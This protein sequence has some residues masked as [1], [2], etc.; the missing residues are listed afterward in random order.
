M[1]QN[2]P[3]SYQQD[4]QSLPHN[5][6][7]SPGNVE[8]WRQ[9][10][11]QQNQGP[12]G[13]A[14]PYTSRLYQPGEEEVHA[15]AAKLMEL[16]FAIVA[17]AE[18][19]VEELKEKEN[20]RLK[21]EQVC[22]ELVTG[23]EFF[24]NGMQI[25]PHTIELKCF[26][27]LASGF[28]TKA[29][30]MDL[31]LLSPYS[32]L[33]PDAPG[34]PLPR[35][36]EKAFLEMG[37][38]A[39]LLTR[40]RVPIIKI[41]ERPPENLRADLIAARVKWEAGE[42]VGVDGLDEEHPDEP[43]P[44]AAD[45]ENHHESSANLGS[46]TQNPDAESHQEKE[47]AAPPK[48]ERADFSAKLST[49]KQSNHTLST[50]Y[51]MAKTVLRKVGCFDMTQ[52]NAATYLPE[53]VEKLGEVCHA[54]VSGLADAELK[55]RLFS[56]H[57][58]S[59]TSGHYR[60]LAG[61]LFQTEGENM[62]MGWTHR[63]LPEKDE[64][65]EQ[66][67]QREL[68]A[69]IQIQNKVDF[70]VD[71]VSYQK[72]LQMGLER[73]K[74]IPSLQINDFQQAQFESAAT[75]H[76]RAIH[77]L[78]ELGG[79]DNLDPANKVLP[80]IVSRYIAGIYNT[81]VRSGVELH[82][83]STSTRSLRAIAR[84]HKSL[85][86]AHDFEKALDKGHYQDSDADVVRRY[87]AC[88]RRPMTV[89]DIY[90]AH[91]DCIVEKTKSVDEI[92]PAIL[93]LGNPAKLA[94]NQPRDP[95]KDP[96]E[97][98]KTGA[99]V[100]CDVNFSAHLALHNTALLRCYSYTDPR[101]TPMVLFVKH[102]AKVRDINNPYRGTLSSYGYV[103]M[104]IHYLVNVVQ[105]FVCPNLQLLA[106]PD[107]PNMPPEHAVCKGYNVR[108]W[109]DEATIQRLASRNE[110][111]QNRDSLGYLLRGF[112][113]YYAY[114]GTMSAYPGVRGFDWGRDTL[115]LRT[116][117]GILSKQE[118][119]WTGAKTVTEVK[120]VAAPPP[121][122]G[123]E[124][125]ALPPT[126]ELPTTQ[127]VKEVRHRYLF[128]IE[129]PF[130]LDHNVARTVTHNGIVA[131]RDEFRRAWRLIKDFGRSEVQED[132]LED[133]A[134]AEEGKNREFFEQLLLEIHGDMVSDDKTA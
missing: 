47:D 81:E 72:Q 57:S 88:L 132:L 64:H 109:R 93:R 98:P 89:P 115:S 125:Q 127:E 17:N 41:C 111:N 103:L 45:T 15:Q 108:F 11:R 9:A 110:L 121:V 34:S 3:L 51:N 2:R 48:D 120:T 56:Y 42:G 83:T 21:L 37:I 53:N 20:F 29:A 67:A 39:R 7:Q 94:L 128:A 129:D 4:R 79:A 100:Q 107:D 38:G 126:R 6:P 52:S 28:A 25:P 130:E 60:T 80:V 123:P 105:P 8:N 62:A 134:K 95:Y 14:R 27:S 33:Q 61:V 102:W 112:F 59:S 131:V 106:P 70:H 74:R 43:V 19:S 13:Q 44:V 92:L 114:N 22:R 40:T 1:I 85:Q 24:C 12:R 82:A 116:P 90:D 75:Y 68:A 118:K 101:V 18:I 71:P 30:D 104:V 76:R 87:I 54:F 65:Q 46:K 23:H 122:V 49:L 84:R 133:V 78:I 10:P 97:F 31:A 96:L 66:L 99:G 73:L 86:L 50:Y 16:A 55:K 36:L 32:T 117:R 124:G 58:L 35:L 77:L 91:F 69:W 113:E 63:P 5:A 26:G 119:G